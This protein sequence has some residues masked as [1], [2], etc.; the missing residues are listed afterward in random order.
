MT[1]TELN[2]RIAALAANEAAGDRLKEKEKVRRRRKAEIRKGDRWL[3]IARDWGRNPHAGY[4]E[5]SFTARTLVHSGR[6]ITY[7]KSSRS[8]VDLK[9]ETSAAARRYRYDFP[10]KGNSYRRLIDFWWELY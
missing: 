3:H 7:F 4:I 1:E 10:V 5:R 8:R 2:G 6:Y 9:Q